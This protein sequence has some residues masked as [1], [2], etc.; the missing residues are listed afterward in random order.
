MI[1]NETTRACITGATSKLALAIIQRL[2]DKG[3]SVFATDLKDL[4]LNK[5]KEFFSK[6]GHVET[7]TCN[8]SDDEQR[9]KLIKWMIENDINL[10]INNAGLGLYG[11]TFA[12]NTKDQLA[13]ID[14]NVKALSDICLSYA[15]DRIEKK[16]TGLI[17]N[18]SSATD[19]LIFPTFSIYTAT[20]AYTTSLSQSLNGEFKEHGIKVLTSSPGTINTDFRI[21]A[22]K[23]YYTQF[24]SKLLCLA[25]A[26]SPSAAAK[27]IIN[28]IE[29]EKS[30]LCFPFTTKL[31]RKLLKL[32]GKRFESNFLKKT[33][34]R[35]FP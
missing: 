24:N 34:R 19:S 32:M 2:L 9:K 4:E 14:I 5:T 6:E 28:Q 7:Y 35:R 23:G 27:Y 29:K 21:H 15:Q 18:I 22:S 33:L 1:L 26:L 3:A 25:N 12:H 11:P 10:V 30:Y 20:K 13:I 16:K 8:L 17:L 31:L